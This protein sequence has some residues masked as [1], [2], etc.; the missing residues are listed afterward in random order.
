MRVVEPDVALPE[1][2]PVAGG[3]AAVA[4][5]STDELSS[6]P[7]AGLAEGVASDETPDPAVESLTAGLVRLVDDVISTYLSRV[8]DVAGGLVRMV[9]WLLGDG[10][11]VP[12]PAKV[13]HIPPAAPVPG[14]PPPVVPIPTGG[15]PVGGGSFSNGLTSS[16]GTSGFPVEKYGAWHILSTPLLQGCKLFW[17]SHQLLRP[18]SAQQSAIER[19]G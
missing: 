19:P 2:D 12:S 5:G 14:I 9:S 7:V 15:S 13:P 8:A 18:S 10:G 6:E 1:G 16:G 3:A 11:E 4:P 17:P